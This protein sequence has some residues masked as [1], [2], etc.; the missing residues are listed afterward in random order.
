MRVVAGKHFYLKRRVQKEANSLNKNYR[1]AES[2][3][4]KEGRLES[5]TLVVITAS[6]RVW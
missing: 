1:V 4:R 3:C 2:G 6:M 5:E